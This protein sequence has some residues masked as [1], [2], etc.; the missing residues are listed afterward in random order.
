MIG[1]AIVKEIQLLLHDRGAL[2]SLFALPLIFVIA[3]G[4][5][6]GG[7]GGG[8]RARV[9]GVHYHAE[10]K[11]AARIVAALDKSKT[12]RVK[13]IDTVK[14]VE[15]YVAGK[16][17]RVGLILPHK[18]D[19]SG[20]HPAELIID[21]GASIRF[22]GPI[23]GA[24]HGLIMRAID[25]AAAASEGPRMLITRSPPGI[26]K[27]LKGIDGF[28]VS[29]PGNAVLFGFFLAL[30]VALS[31]VEERKS[32]TWRRLLAAPV[33]R[34]TLLVAKLVPYFIVGLVQMAFLLGLGALAF[35]MQ[36]AG[37]VVALCVLTVA[38]VFCA[39]ALGLFIASFG[40]TEKQVGSVGS[41]IILV[42]GLL[43]GAMV[44]RLMMPETMQKIGLA[45]PHGWALEGYYDVLIRRG[46]TLADIAGPI[47]AVVGFGVVFTVIGALNFKFER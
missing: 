21:E 38:V 47:V 37:S 46:T 9:I 25:P 44:P 36:V 15:T 3:F 8:D 22:R 29:V 10:N 34:P 18:M 33:H 24:V 30:T 17:G 23:I 41:I 28:Q 40:G 20:K 45:V 1:P 39:V 42:M 14:G 6:F 19:P 32:G 4:S 5:M 2:A 35:G 7:G 12:F 16:D 26:K 43:G 13:A 27:P 31:F 11:T